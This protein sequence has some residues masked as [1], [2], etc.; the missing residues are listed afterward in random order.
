[1][2]SQVRVLPSPGLVD[3]ARTLFPLRR[4]TG[5]LATVEALGEGVLGALEQPRR[6]VAR[7]VAE[8]LGIAAEATRMSWIR[9]RARS[10]WRRW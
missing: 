6:H 3:L 8:E 2:G 1:M 4:G 7:H 5:D 9:S 10:G